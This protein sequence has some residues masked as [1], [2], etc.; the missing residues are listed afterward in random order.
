VVTAT[1]V[2]DA[3]ALGGTAASQTVTAGGTLHPFSSVTLT[4]PTWGRGHRH[5]H[6]G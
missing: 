2:N 6:A 4:D 3:P 1:S 5:H